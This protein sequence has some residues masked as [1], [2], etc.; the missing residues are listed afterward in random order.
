MNSHESDGGFTLV[1]VLIVMTIIG[2]L[3][4]ML[5]FNFRSSNSNLTARNQTTAAVVAD[6]RRAQTMATN[7]TLFQGQIVCG[8]GVHYIAGNNNYLIYARQKPAGGSCTASG[9][10]NYNQGSI[11]YSDAIVQNIFLANPNMEL[12]PTCKNG[13]NISFNGGDIFFEPPDPKTYLNNDSTLSART[14]DIF[15]RAKTTSGCNAPAAVI[16]I[17]TAGSINVQ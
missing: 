8:Y 10:R 1:E 9:N 16:N 2:F 15:V 3:S 5:F 13:P 4:I 6:I 11:G 17:T 14:M 7:S 12:Q